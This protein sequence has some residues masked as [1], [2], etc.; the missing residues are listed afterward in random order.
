MKKFMI[1]CFLLLGSV[2]FA[3]Y[4]AGLDILKKIDENMSSDNRILTSKMI[5]HGRRSS[6]TISSKNWAQGEKRSFSE[7][8]L[9]ARE[10]GIKMLKLNDKLWTY[11]PSTDRTIQIAGHMLRQSVMGSDLSYEDMM[12]DTKLSEDYDA[13][14]TGTE[15]VASRS[16]FIVKLEA[17][18]AEVAY[19]TRILWVDEE[20]YVPA[21]EELY[22][23]SGKLLKT[24]ELDN[25]KQIDDR[26]FPMRMIYKDVLKNG[27]GT[28]FVVDSIEF[29][30]PIPDHVFSKA[31]LRR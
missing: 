2:V 22:A 7:Y 28:E 23:K 4:P 8:L 24:T 18:K 13:L 9:P 16:C 5:I 10:R 11:S 27:K 20:R 1:I 26:W 3:Q 25:F 21:R 15:M 6:R 31:S 30:S 19:Q 17:K 29:N 14:V 12:N